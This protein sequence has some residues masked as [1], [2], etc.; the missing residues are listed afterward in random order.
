M[1]IQQQQESGTIIRVS[2]ERR[3]QK[4]NIW[5]LVQI[6]SCTFTLIRFEV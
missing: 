5:I 4:R 2:C 1:F 3:E 6:F